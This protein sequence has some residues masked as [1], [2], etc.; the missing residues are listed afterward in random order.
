MVLSGMGNM[1]MVED[2]VSYMKDFKPLDAR[3]RAAIDKVVDILHSQPLIS[4]TDCK[5]CVERC[6]LS[7]QIPTVFSAK[8]T[9]TRLNLWRS[10][11]L[12][13]KAC[14]E[15]ASPAECLGCGAC[16]AACP[17]KLP[18]R[19]LLESISEEFNK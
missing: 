9:K 7:I 3:E 6:P 15:G 10:G 18:I 2:N 12:Y 4:C 17:Q 19:D 8:N 5:Y 14:A 1:E 11:S 13:K 16:E